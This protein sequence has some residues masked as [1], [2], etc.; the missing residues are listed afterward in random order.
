[1]AK[2]QTT[3]KGI[4]SP[5]KKKNAQKNKTLTGKKKNIH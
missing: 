5:C 4:I 1:M 2:R 3:A